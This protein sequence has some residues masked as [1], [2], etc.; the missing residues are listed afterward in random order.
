MDSVRRGPA[1]LATGVL[2]GS[3]LGVADD[4]SFIAFEHR[5]G[6]WSYAA[7]FLR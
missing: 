3:I 4:Y 2:T 1:G 6:R 5:D 7:A